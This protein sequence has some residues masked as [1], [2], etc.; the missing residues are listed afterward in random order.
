MGGAAMAYGPFYY[1]AADNRIYRLPASLLSHPLSVT[2]DFVGH[3]IRAWSRQTGFRDTAAIR[4]ALYLDWDNFGDW[5]DLLW[6]MQLPS[7]QYNSMNENAFCRHLVSTNDTD[8]VR[9]LCWSR[10]MRTYATAS[11]RLGITIAVWKTTR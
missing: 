7:P 2:E 8:A 5:A 4:R 11:V 6:E 1:S 10:P 9:L 3:N